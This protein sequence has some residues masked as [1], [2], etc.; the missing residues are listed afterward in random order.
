MNNLFQLRKLQKEELRKLCESHKI[1]FSSVELLLE[2]EKIKKLL[3]RK[4]LIQQTID[5]E[6]EKALK[7]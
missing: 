7:K 3:N 4:A 2:A 5:S 1:D 6:I